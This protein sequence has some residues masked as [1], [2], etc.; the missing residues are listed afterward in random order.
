MHMTDSKASHSRQRTAQGSTGS[1]HF[2]LDQANLVIQIDSSLQHWKPK[3]RKDTSHDSASNS[4]L[5]NMARE[6]RD[7]GRGHGHHGGHGG[8]GQGRS[9]SNRSK[10]NST[11]QPEMK[12]HPHGIGC[13]R[14]TVTHETVKDH[15]T[16]CVQRMHKEGHDIAKS[17]RDLE[18]TDLSGE[19]PQRAMSA[20]SDNAT[21]K[22]EQDGLDVDCTMQSKMHLEQVHMLDQN[23]T[24]TCA[25]VHSTCC[26][27]T[28]QNRIQEHPDCESKIRDDPIE[29]LK[30]IKVPMH[31]PTRVKCPHASLVEAT[32]RLV[33]VE[34]MENEDLLDHVK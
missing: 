29:L 15:I 24:K 16:L 32:S 19:K 14:Q 4:S 11:K 1:G 33:D 34:Q 27:K 23:L 2:R 3:G 5:K 8:R 10:A 9:C 17:I 6:G 21:K 30:A 25:L 12:F 20:A 18:K 31:D 7:S 22:I 13:E 26:D 28:M